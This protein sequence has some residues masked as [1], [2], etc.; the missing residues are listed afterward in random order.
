MDVDDWKLDL[1]NFND[2]FFISDDM[3]LVVVR[4]FKDLG[5]KRIFRIDIEVGVLIFLYVLE[6]VYIFCV[7]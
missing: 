4:I 3:L 7:R 6:K 1:F 2:F 5:F